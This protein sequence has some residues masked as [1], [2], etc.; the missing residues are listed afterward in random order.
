MRSVDR[1]QCMKHSFDIKG[2]TIHL[3]RRFSFKK[4]FQIFIGTYKIQ[5]KVKKNEFF[6]NTIK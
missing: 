2:D 6:F 3:S 5:I 1:S 4:L